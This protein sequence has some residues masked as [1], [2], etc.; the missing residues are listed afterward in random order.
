MNPLSD[1]F[2]EL[3]LPEHTA[4]PDLKPQ[5]WDK[6]H[7]NVMLVGSIPNSAMGERVLHDLLTASIQRMGVFRMG[8]VEMYMFCYKDAVQVS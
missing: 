5:S 7:E 1:P 8:R 3:L 6:V 4:I 2:D